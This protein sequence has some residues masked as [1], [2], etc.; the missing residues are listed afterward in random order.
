MKKNKIMP[1][2]LAAA[3]TLTASAGA[4]G[5]QVGESLKVRDYN[6]SAA[7]TQKLID[8]RP[9]IQRPM[10]KLNRGAVAIRM[11]GYTYISWR[12]LGT[13][14]A[15]T[16]F[17][18][19]TTDSRYISGGTNREKL[20]SE[21]LN[22]TNYIDLS[23][24]FN[25]ND[26]EYSIQGADNYQIVPVI[27]GVEQ[28][29][30][31]ELAQIWDN[32]Y[33]DI[34]IQKPEDN[35]VNGEKYTYTPSDAS[36]GDLDGDGEY[37][38]VLK[39]DPSN[40]K[41][42]AQA[43]FTG[44]CVIDAYKMDGT[45]MWRVNMGPNIR[46][47]QHDTQFMVYDY[48]GDGKA[49]MACRTADGTIAGDGTVIGDADKNYAVENNG[50]NLT[51][52]LYL[53]VFKGEDGSVID[54]VDYD[55]QTQ[56]KTKSGYKWDVITWG[57]DPN[58]EWGN[59]SE[60][61][62]AAVAYL[63]GTRPSMVFCRGYYT[64]PGGD[65]GG[66]TVIAAYDLI[67]GKIVQK[68]RFD[69]LD[70]NN[71]YIGQGNHS[72]SAAD[73]DYDGCDELIY[74]S[75]AVDH[76][77]K[78]MYSTGLGHGDAQHVGDLDPSR[79]GLEVY[80]CHEEHGAA[81]GYE[82]R[83]AR[84]GE[85][86]YG[87][88]TGND[89]GRGTAGDID[90]RYKG[91]EGWSAAGVLTAADGTVISNKY[92]M[93]ANFLCWWDG[94]LGREIQDNIYIS[95]WNGEKNKAETIFTASGC[96]AV[97]G[98]KA[99]PSLTADLFGDWREEIMYPLKDGSALRIYTT[100][101]PTS[102]KLPTLMHDIQYRMHI[103]Y[104]NDCYNQPPHLSYYLGYDTETVPVPQITVNGVKNPDLSKKNWSIDNLYSGE[105]VELVLDCPTALVNGVPVRVDNDNTDVRPYLD[106]NDRTLVPIRFIAEAF[107]CEVDWHG[108]I[109]SL[110]I[111]APDNKIIGMSI[112]SNSYSVGDYAGDTA[113]TPG[114]GMVHVC[115]NEEQKE[116]DTAPVLMNDRTMVPL[117]AIAEALRK[118]VLY[119][120]GYIAI[121]DIDLMQTYANAARK[122]I[123][124]SAPV[125]AK[126]ERVAI[127][128][129]GK[130]YY[131]N[132][133]DI[134]A[135]EASDNDGNVETGA[136]DLD[137]TT[138]WSAFGANT[139]T[140]DLGE[141]KNVAGVAIAMWKGNERIYPFTIEYSNDGVTWEN[142]LPKTQNTGE[143]EEFE[144]YMFS[145]P[146]KARYVRY[147]GDGAT[148]PKK[149]YC[150]ISEIAVLGAVAEAGE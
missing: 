75:L 70:Y 50:K 84:T 36:V 38:I 130:K 45:R 37:E 32:N 97:N 110:H 133:L 113:G 73:V 23:L 111:I 81:Y 146:V 117:R 74:G 131:D 142:A 139:L 92:T 63:D 138:R 116:M 57:D 115:E 43:G 62:L 22:T 9:D 49:E 40:A 65:I 96:S 145:A 46:A 4:L 60:R 59:R 11:D 83:D 94:D 123:I 106:K 85:I 122:D 53:T 95:K 5:A 51:G 44:E 104:Q 27:D 76:D 136:V 91:A 28:F 99:N 56:G 102:Y 39:W 149:N 14:S 55:P 20:N 141:E 13:E 112:G 1:A 29:D 119:L 90:P 148:D 107:G 143:T 47:G 61:Y 69:T 78:P 18:V 58:G 52:P 87:E 86:L 101:T 80:S 7:Q 128:G 89:N 150:H 54:T 34:P 2:I 103:A 12:W 21:P 25:Y 3:M 114:S 17:N 144:K 41:D 98:T 137:I 71:N 68:W 31:A 35:E 77:G 10:E 48:D 124:M 67:D 135:V 88:K 42:A 26:K 132:Q 108:D 72:M 126:V 121:S 147:S 15:D 109:Q 66:R 19:Y 127:N 82:M 100:T 8:A 120:N 140:L 33:I 118:Q 134:F 6:E 79:P 93:P 129:T 64:G 125:P 30:K 24:E 105:M 16:K